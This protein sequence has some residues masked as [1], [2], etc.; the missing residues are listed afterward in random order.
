[1][2][3]SG[4][5]GDDFTIRKFQWLDQVCA[6]QGLKS[7]SSF[8]VAYRLSCHLNRQ[9]GV[10]RPSQETVAR[11]LGLTVRTVQTCIAELASRGHLEVQSGKGRHQVSRYRPILKPGENTKPNSSLPS[12]TTKPT[13]PIKPENTKPAS[14]LNPENTKPAAQKHEVQRTKTRS[15]LR[16]ELFEEQYEEPFESVRDTGAG[17]KATKRRSQKALP[18]DCPNERDR[19]W[20]LEHWR[21]K[22]RPDLCEAITE[23]I[24]RFRDY[25]LKTGKLWA[26]WSAAWRNWS[27]NAVTFNAG[28]SSLPSYQ[29]PSQFKIHKVA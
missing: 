27:R 20:A 6:D 14:P 5:S 25:H 13:S 24:E 15:G 9:E 11:A 1:M 10:S 22:K 3:S 28:K 19:L 16:T 17:P 7:S 26:D 23:Q 18:D 29:D 12:E 4:D 2:D 21:A 8:R